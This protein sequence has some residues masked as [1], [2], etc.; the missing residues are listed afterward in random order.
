MSPAS[1]LARAL[2]DY[3]PELALTISR[4]IASELGAGGA[5]AW[6]AQKLSTYLAGLTTAEWTSS[7]T[8]EWKTDFAHTERMRALG[9]E[10]A[11]RL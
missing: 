7:T 6:D 10:L 3:D 4:A 11:S 1:D 9:L 8:S 2:V 5:E